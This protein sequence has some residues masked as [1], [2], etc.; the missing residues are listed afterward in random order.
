MSAPTAP[1]QIGQGTSLSQVV[2]NPVRR[3][4]TSWTFLTEAPLHDFPI[5]DEILFQSLRLAAD[6][7]ICE[8]GLGTGFTPFWLASQVRSYTGIDVSAATVDRLRQDLKH[9]KNAE[10]VCADLASPEV[11]AV[12]TRRFDVVYGLDVFEYVPKPGVCLRNLAAML[13]PGGM[14]L[15][16]YPN[17]PPPR[18]DGV[19][20][21][22]Q[23][24]DLETLI[25]GAGFSRWV[26]S[27]LRLRPWAR[28]V[29]MLLHEWPIHLYRGRNRAAKAGCPQVYE[30]TWAFQ[31]GQQLQRYRPYL[32]SYW[33]VLGVL[34]RMSG[35]VYGEYG[36]T[37]GQSMLGRQV[38]IRAWK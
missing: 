26:V 1:S 7:E 12:V 28:R 37:P 4:S 8:V 34:V 17:V 35:P 30:Q 27:E 9:L 32:H 21:F 23:Q 24:G 5:R 19:T 29:Y 10:F 11:P 36:L 14:L 18:G 3:P 6:M 15:L 2:G 22:E 31:H 25:A 38:L 33:A 16:S 13:R 20:W